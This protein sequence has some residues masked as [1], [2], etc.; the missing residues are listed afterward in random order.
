MDIIELLPYSINISIGDTFVQLWSIIANWFTGLLTNFLALPVHE[1]IGQVLGIIVTVGCILIAQLPKRSQILLAQAFLNIVSAANLLLVS[2]G[3]SGLTASLPCFVAVIHCSVNV[4]R[5][6]FGSRS[7]LWEKILF[8]I[9]YFI[10]WGVGFTISLV[11]LLNQEHTSAELWKLI[12][13]ALLPL[14]ATAFFVASVFM[15]KEQR[16]RLCSLG[17]AGS[18]VAYNLIT[19]NTAVFAHIFTIISITIALIRYRKKPN[20]KNTLPDKE[21]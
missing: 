16:M 6:K 2:D 7:P 4:I 18:Y 11:S 13:T 17:N 20:E 3:L 15:Q 5:E 14:L 1:K 19:P 8:S 21:N 10:A 12:L 9:L